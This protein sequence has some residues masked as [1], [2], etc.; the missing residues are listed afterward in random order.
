MSSNSDLKSRNSR[1][2][3]VILAVVAGMVG[4]AFASVPLYRLFCQ[5]T[6]FGGTTQVAAALPGEVIDRTITVKFNTD[7]ARNLLW[8]F[9]PDLRQIDLKLGQKG[10]IG[11]TAENKDRAPLT[12]TALYNVT[13]GKAGKYFHKIQ[14]FCFGSQT[15][16]PGEKADYP[17]VFYI[18]PR[19]HEDPN[20]ADV[21]VITLSYTFFPSDTPELEAA[22]ED[23]YKRAETAGTVALQ[24]Q[25]Q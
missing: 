8:S 21:R 4:M 23:F 1:F 25:S 20:M 2:L 11:F 16:K 6:G 14:C 12:G 10:V 13:P 15:L 7:V 3:V 24:P 17:V 18:D 5:V 22:M 9:K 19:L